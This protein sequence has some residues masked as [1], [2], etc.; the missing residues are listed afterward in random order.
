MRTSLRFVHSVPKTGNRFFSPLGPDP[1]L[2]SGRTAPTSH[3]ASG[4]GIA[5]V[6]HSKP[7]GDPSPLSSSPEP[8]RA[9]PYASLPPAPPLPPR[10]RLR[11]GIAGPRTPAR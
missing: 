9:A 3:Q 5:L 6:Q 4:L 2:L 7:V 11:A 1:R 10:A 8:H